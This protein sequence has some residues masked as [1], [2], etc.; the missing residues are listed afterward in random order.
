MPYIDSGT[1][2][3]DAETRALTFPFTEEA[4]DVLT[5]RVQRRGAEILEYLGASSAMSCASAI[6]K[7]LKVRHCICFVSLLLLLVVVLRI[8]SQ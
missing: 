6:S 8:A 2:T 5:A 4:K 3:V 1:F 7:H